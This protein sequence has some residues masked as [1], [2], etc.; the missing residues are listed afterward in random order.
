MEITE[1]GY[2][3]IASGCQK[4]QVLRMYACAHVNDATLRACG[5]LL[6][7]L[8]IIDICGAHLVTDSGAQVSS[9]YSVKCA[10]QN[11]DCSYC[12]V[13]YPV[14]YA[15]KQYVAWLRPLSLT[16]TL[17]TMPMQHTC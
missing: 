8:R 5:E 12:T 14:E 2:T 15:V 11:L 4:L 17:F 3:A 7:D 16:T 6:L 13:L 1:N 9:G 10:P